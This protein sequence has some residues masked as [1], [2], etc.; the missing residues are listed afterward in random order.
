MALI[1]SMKT[2]QSCDRAYY[3]GRPLPPDTHTHSPHRLC[4]GFGGVFRHKDMARKPVVSG[5]LGDEPKVP[6][7]RKAGIHL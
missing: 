2:L 6:V 3:L 7:G 1:L 5:V 4:Q